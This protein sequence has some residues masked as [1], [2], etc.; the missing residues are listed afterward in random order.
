MAAPSLGGRTDRDRRLILLAVPVR[1]HATVAVAVGTRELLRKSLTTA[2][3][4]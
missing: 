1:C 3:G 2:S 4:L